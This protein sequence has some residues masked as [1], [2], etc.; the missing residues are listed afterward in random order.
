MP[1]CKY[2]IALFE[3]VGQAQI[4]GSCFW[5]SIPASP[6]SLLEIQIFNSF[7]TYFT[8]SETLGTEIFKLTNPL[9][10]LMQQ[11]WRNQ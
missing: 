2:H 7:P 10:T 11:K 8:E 9:M 6:R 3:V 4:R 5:T 1:F